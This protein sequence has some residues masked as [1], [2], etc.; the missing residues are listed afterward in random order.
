MYFSVASRTG[1]ASRLRARLESDSFAL[2]S[3]PA[4]ELSEYWALFTAPH[5]SAWFVFRRAARRIVFEVVCAGLAANV[6]FDE[7][8]R[9]IQRGAVC[10]TQNAGSG[11]LPDLAG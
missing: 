5:T 6:L 7:S 1:L 4:I 11:T 8:S 2:T 3:T 9:A 10:S